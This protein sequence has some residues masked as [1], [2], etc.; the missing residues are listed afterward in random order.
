MTHTPLRFDVIPAV[1]L[2]NGRCVRLQQGEMD[3]ETIYHEDPVAAALRWAELGARR[4]HVV[5]LDGAVGNN[6]KNHAV[7]GRIAASVSIPVQA[8]GGIRE[9]ET[10]NKLLDAGIDRIILG[11]AAVT[12]PQ[13]VKRLCRRHP[14]RIA[15]GIDARAGCVAVAG[16]TQTTGVRA[17]DL[18]RRIEEMGTAVIIFTDIRRDG[19]MTGPNFDETRKL[20]EAVSIP[21]IISGG[22][23]SLAD[24]KQAVELAPF[25]VTGVITGRALYDGRLDL[26]AALTL[27][28]ETEKNEKKAPKPI[29]KE[30]HRDYI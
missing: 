23:A 5:D 4:L 29:D 11:T 7:I 28:K 25:G 24:I 20:A 1:D 15:L 30:F 8:G 3:R 22:V 2:K 19:M 27:A 18:A 6:R 14:G 26:E 9:E 13:L 17:V 16:W 21:V 12:N 10:A